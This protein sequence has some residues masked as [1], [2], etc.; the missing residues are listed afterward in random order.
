MCPKKKDNDVESIVRI[1]SL[2]GE[3]SRGLSP[4][5][6]GH[7]APCDEGKSS[8]ASISSSSSSSEN[9][10][11]SA[12]PSTTGAEKY[13]FVTEA[14]EEE[15]PKSSNYRVTP[16]EPQAATARLQIPSKAKLIGG[17]Q[18][19][20]LGLMSSGHECKFLE[21]AGSSF[22]IPHEEE[23]INGFSLAELITACGDF[24]LKNFVASWC[25]ARKLER[26][27]KETKDSS[28][29]AVASVQNQV[30]E[31]EKLLAAEQDRNQRL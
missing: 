15:D 21:Q 2:V 19:R 17:K 22:A 11:L 4:P 29:A 5:P 25:L 12:S 10:G 28:A 7:E 9:T 16:E 30:T 6:F 27:D 8:S 20:F 1:V 26:E 18:I 24:T 14:E 3:A 13:D 23:Y 31:L